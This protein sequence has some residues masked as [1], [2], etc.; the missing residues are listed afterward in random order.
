MREWK[1]T[2]LL[3]AAGRAVM[4][5]VV[6]AVWAGQ[7]AAPTMKCMKWSSLHA[8]ASVLRGCLNKLAVRRQVGWQGRGRSPG[9]PDRK[10]V[11][12]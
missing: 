8:A 7:V 1:V 2:T 6:V 4:G 3:K 5:P 10:W 9:M 12:L 11:F